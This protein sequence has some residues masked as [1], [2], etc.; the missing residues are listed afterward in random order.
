M[1][2]EQS[3]TDTESWHPVNHRPGGGQCF[4]YVIFHV[5]QKSRVT[6]M[7]INYIE[8]IHYVCSLEI[9]HITVVLLA[10]YST[11]AAMVAGAMKTY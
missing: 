11:K 1:F 4:R 2:R 3:C 7:A 6:D 8:C 10:P 9:K 5:L